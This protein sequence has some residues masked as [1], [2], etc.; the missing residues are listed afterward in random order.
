ML[1]PSH[2]L[3]NL[4]TDFPPPVTAGKLTPAQVAASL[5]SDFSANTTTVSADTMVD[6]GDSM[7][8]GPGLEPLPQVVQ[9]N[10]QQGQ[11][12]PVQPP[13]IPGP[14]DKGQDQPLPQVL[15]P[16]AQPAAPVQ[17]PI[18]SDPLAAM[19][20]SMRVAFPHETP[21]QI[22]KRV[23]DALTPAIPDQQEPMVDPDAVRVDEIDTQVAALRKQASD[24]G[25]SD[26]DAEISNL[27]REKLKL[28]TRLEVRNELQEDRRISEFAN[29]AN[30]WE[31]LAT[32]AFPDADVPGSPL[33]A[34]I[35]AKLTEVLARDPDYFT[36]SPDAGYALVAGEAAKLGYAPK[37]VPQ[38]AAP[39]PG[40]PQNITVPVAMPGSMQ[41][42]HR[43]SSQVQPSPHQA[44]AN[45]LAAAQQGGFAAELALARQMSR[46]GF[47]GDG[48]QFVN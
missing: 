7:H 16:P 33:K 45:Q 25:T 2:P 11:Q 21:A 31:S 17:A 9:P 39:A 23:S 20:A 26:F 8:D 14:Q 27:E 37:V 18:Q 48:V 41:G 3:F 22:A 47:V 6:S 44:F 42:S 5:P 29:D 10:P 43:P 35:D 34:A 30:R 36:R 24:E 19:T 1:R 32:Q 28:E 46:G 13:A 40:T 38:G 4:A 12:A 15:Q